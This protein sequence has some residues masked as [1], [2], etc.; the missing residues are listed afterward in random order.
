M[1]GGRQNLVHRVGERWRPPPFTPNTTRWQRL[2]SALRRFVDLQAGSIWN[3]LAVEL[4]KVSG[5]LLDVG[6][7]AQP[8]RSLLSTMV[9]YL[10]IDTIDAKPHF[11]YQTGDTVY[12][13]GTAWPVKD[14]SADVVLCTETLEH[15]AEPSA[16]LDEMHRCLRPGGR[17]VL[18]VP[19]AAR[20]HFIPHDYWRFT[21]SGL[22]RLLTRAGFTNIE[23]Y[24]RGNVLTVACYKQMALFLPLLLPQGANPIWRWGLRILGL[25]ASPFFLIAAVVGNLSMKMEGGDD[26]LGYTVLAERG[27]LGPAMLAPDLK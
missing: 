25:A 15:I 5:T 7:G 24:A 11:G 21:P 1:S 19:F 4:P 17:V 26:C 2:L 13:S 10:G 14:G 9:N 20:W 3:D 8:Y 6:C 23:I 22:Q 12:Y 18:T 16:F 27:C